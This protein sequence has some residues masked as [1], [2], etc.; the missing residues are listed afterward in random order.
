MNH[1][2][3]L[4]I[5]GGLRERAGQIL[6]EGDLLAEGHA[7]GLVDAAMTIEDA[8]RTAAAPAPPRKEGR[9]VYRDESH[10]WAR[11]WG[12]WEHKSDGDSVPGA[13]E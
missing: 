1:T 11:K 8:V 3:F 4:A 9:C 6:V 13:G 10:E 5:A 2:E 7:S 12:D